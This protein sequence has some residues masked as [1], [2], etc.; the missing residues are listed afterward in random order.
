MFTSSTRLA[1]HLASQPR[2][3]AAGDTDPLL[4]RRRRRR[5]LTGLV[6][7]TTALGATVLVAP[8][9][10]A[11]LTS[12]GPIDP[13][14]NFPSY[15]TDGSGL[16]LELCLAG[17]PSCL[18][19][20]DFVQIHNDGGDAEAFYYALDAEAGPFTLH[21]A[22]EAAYAADGPDQEVVFQRTEVRAKDAGLPADTRYTVTDPYGTFTCTTDE[23]GGIDSNGCRIET[24]PVEREF[25]RALSG[26]NARLGPFV[27]WDGALPPGYIGDNVTPH[28]VTGSPTGFNA[29]RVQGP[30]LTTTC[31][32]GTIRNCVETDEFIVQGK[33]ADTGVPSASISAGTLDFGDV[34]TTPAVTKT[35]TYA[36]TG[37]LPV[38]IN[39]I[40][41]GGTNASRFSQTNNC[42]VAPA[43]LAAGA[44]CSID[45][46]FTPQ[47]GAASAATLTITDNTP[48]ATRTVALKGSNLPVMFVSDPAPPA[49]LTFG[50]VSVGSTSVEDN[51]V[52]GNSGNGPLTVSTVAITGTSAS[53]FQL[54]PNTGCTGVTVAPD[55]G[56]E[57]GVQFKPTTTGSKT[58]NLRVTDSTGK[59]VNVPLTGTG[60]TAPAP[61]T[62]LPTM[63]TLTGSLSGT[64]ANL[65]WGAATDNVGVTGY[66]VFRNGVQQG[67]DLA[68]SARSFSQTGLAAGTYNYTVRAFDAARNVSA[69]SNTVTL[70]VPSA[71][72]VP[73]APAIGTASRGNASATVN[74][75]APAPNGGTAVTSYQVQ[76]RTGTTVLRTVTGI[77]ATARTTVV[78][79]LTNGTA[80]NFRVRAVNAA[81]PGAL[82]AA[83]NTVTPATTPGAPVIGTAVAGAA[84]GVIQAT[85]NWTPPTSTGGSAITGY[86]VRALRMSSTGTVLATTTSAVQASTARS[87]TMTL[88]VAGNYRFTVQARNAVG[89]GAQS[90]R[91]NLVTGR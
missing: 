28:T 31:A 60:G 24:T 14:T 37:T 68:A 15:Y 76:V 45:V 80:Y 8:A 40:A 51:V 69:A 23:T 22:L 85:A 89:D 91:S 30:G 17:D 84:G 56:C 9:A 48:A 64:T 18:A 77:A 39:G 50:T 42:P 53:H 10:S 25:G 67:A 52:I 61:D 36:N 5:S 34:P 32:G 83:S 2:H 46:T 13:A 26:A 59:F 38:T 86:V 72:V 29:F 6:A 1:K 81:G 27:T 62:A 47:A 44:R 74:W 4:S 54:G 63:S 75:S 65:S 16:S 88:P 87:L 19:G 33:L 35:L 73:G 78:T 70:T 11:A 71:N 55:G 21:D 12:F 57:I 66:R 58:A 20:P 43:T 41:L 49:G 7:A 90:A 3:R 82:S 79:G